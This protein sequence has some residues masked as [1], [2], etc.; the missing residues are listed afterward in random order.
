MDSASALYAD[1]F[2]T[3]WDKL[4]VLLII[5]CALYLMSDYELNPKLIW[6]DLIQAGPAVRHKCLKAILRMVYFAEAELLQ[7]ILKSHAV[8]R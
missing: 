3:E 2:I 7:D 6:F 4:I 8:S 5:Y 1:D